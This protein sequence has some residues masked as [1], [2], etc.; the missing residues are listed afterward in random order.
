M[1]LIFAT[2]CMALISISSW[3]GTFRDDFEDG[4]WQ[5]WKVFGASLLDEVEEDRFSVVDGVLRMDTRVILAGCRTIRY[6][7]RHE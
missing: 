4:N 6:L 5:G 3:A 2:L 7:G 1:R